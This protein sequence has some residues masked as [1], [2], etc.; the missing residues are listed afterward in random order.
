M[1]HHNLTKVSNLSS[2][3]PSTP[4]QSPPST[5]A[6]SPPSPLPNPPLAPLPIP[7]SPC[8]KVCGDYL[9]GPSTK[10]LRARPAAEGCEDNMETWSAN[11]ITQAT[12]KPL[13]TP[14]IVSNGLP[15]ATSHLH[16]QQSLSGGSIP[17][18]LTIPTT[19]AQQ[20]M[21]FKS[22]SLQE[23]PLRTPPLSPSFHPS[24][25]PPPTTVPPLRSHR[26]MP[27]LP[28]PSSLHS[29]P[30]PVASHQFFRSQSSSTHIA[31]DEAPPPIASRPQSTQAATAFS[32]TNTL[33]HSWRK[34]RR[35]SLHGGT[36]N[37]PYP[38]PL[39][40]PS[41]HTWMAASPPPNASVR[42]NPSESQ[43]QIR[44]TVLPPPPPSRPPMTTP[45]PL[46]EHQISVSTSHSENS[47]SGSVTNV[48]FLLPPPTFSSAPLPPPRTSHSR[49]SSLGKISR[50]THSRNRSHGNISLGDMSVGTST[51]SLPE[52]VV[53][54]NSAFVVEPSAN[55]SPEA[56]G[57]Y[58][59]SRHFNV[60]SQFTSNMALEFCGELAEE[61]PEIAAPP[62]WCMEV[63]NNIIAL[64]CGNG[65]IEVGVA[66]NH[67]IVTCPVHGGTVCRNLES[68][69]IN[70]LK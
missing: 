37:E 55:Q 15:Q 60:F 51:S 48:S 30:P 34:D 31:R 44:H 9:E 3:P 70:I 6:Q 28:L 33:A 11:G 54:A 38:H 43:P 26:R 69:S 41:P 14:P 23:I 65:Q 24:P 66:C 32:N 2:R 10:L 46:M 25:Y 63:W 58:N 56:N 4:A 21:I 36:A 61:G 35:H 68:A 16:H 52:A 64:G 40:P 18:P 22:V 19:S 45:P 53:S 57:G 39:P 47:R 67:V 42:A 29:A 17:P 13:T 1:C 59:F 20:Q 49:S 50:T 62:V 27:S 5:P 12:G 7:P 8:S